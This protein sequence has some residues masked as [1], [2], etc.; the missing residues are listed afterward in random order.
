VFT[1]PET[2]KKNKRNLFDLIKIVEKQKKTYNETYEKKKNSFMFRSI[3]EELKHG[4]GLDVFTMPE[5]VKK[6]KRNLSDLIKIIEKQK[7]VKITLK[8]KTLFIKKHNF[9]FNENFYNKTKQKPLTKHNV[10]EI[11]KKLKVGQNILEKTRIRRL[12]VKRSQM[13]QILIK[14]KSFVKTGLWNSML[15]KNQIKQY[16]VKQIDFIKTAVKNLILKQKHKQ[17]DVTK[18][19]NFFKTAIKKLT[20]KHN[21]AFQYI[22]Q[23]NKKTNN[24]INFKKNSFIKTTKTSL[25]LWKWDELYKKK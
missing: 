14:Q 23:L 11:I 25:S 7:K 1:K 17:Q 19:I 18:Q 9:K 24:L 21:K 3:Y 10:N 4:T 13:P 6:N 2:V 12:A 16:A 22:L 15:K 5:T 20:L 8:P